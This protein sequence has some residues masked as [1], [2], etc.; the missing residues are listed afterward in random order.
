[1]AIK[2]TL[3]NNSEKCIGIPGERMGNVGREN[4]QMLLGELGIVQLINEPAGDV[5]YS[6]INYLY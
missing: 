2:A 6:T 4:D 1:M 3:K 5:G